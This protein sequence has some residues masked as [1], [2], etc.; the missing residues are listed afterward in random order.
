MPC[1]KEQG[2]QLYEANYLLMKYA[3]LWSQTSKDSGTKQSNNQPIFNESFVNVD[4][5]IPAGRK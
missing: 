4:L 1:F 3:L 5:L 2:Q